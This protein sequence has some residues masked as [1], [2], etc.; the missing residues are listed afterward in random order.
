MAE[1]VETGFKKMKR[2]DAPAI[3]DY[4]KLVPPI[5][6]KIKLQIPV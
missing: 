1:L 3:S 6:N 4:L 5:K 2:E